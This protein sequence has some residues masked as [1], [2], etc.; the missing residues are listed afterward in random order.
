MKILIYGI[1]YAPEPTGIGKYTGE[2]AEWLA[3][4]GHEVT[5]VTAP[6]Y[7]PA[8]KVAP[9]YSS[10]LY[11]REIRNGVRVVRCPLWVPRRPT[12][13]KRL[14]HLLSFALSGAPVV[15]AHAFW[16]P[17][18]VFAVAPALFCAPDAWISRSE[19]RESLDSFPRGRST[20]PPSS[21]AGSSGGSTACPL[22]PGL[23]CAD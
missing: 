16:K 19:P 14:L 12:A 15:W 17:D 6:P 18:V 1:N 10:F 8:W 20:P 5:V 9:G 13:V 3:G 22:S 11:R 4:R 2:M 7:Y 21:S 23:W